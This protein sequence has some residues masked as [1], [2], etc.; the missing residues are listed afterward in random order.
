MM[1]EE[2]YRRAYD[3]IKPSQ[4]LVCEVIR[5]AE[6]A[7]KLQGT[8]RK[9]TVWETGRKRAMWAAGVLMAVLC[10][11]VSVLPVCAAKIPAFYRVIEYL[12]PALADS[13][14]PIEK[15]SSD[16]GI[17]MEVE[18]V[19]IEGNEARIIV[20]VR[21]EEG[22]NLD[23]I[24]GPVD[25]FDSY[26]LSS[27]GS[28]QI[29]GGCSFLNY[30][31]E[32][33]RASF[34]V[35]VLSSGRYQ[36]DK[37]RFRVREILCDGSEE[38]REIDLAALGSQADMRCVSLN[39]MGG[40]VE[41]D[42]L[43]DSLKAISEIEDDLKQQWDVLDLMRVEDCAENDFTVT[44]AAYTD[45]ALRLQICM[46]NVRHADR[47]VQPFLV[48]AAG[49]EQ[50]CAFSVSWYEET[51]GQSYQFYEYYFIGEPEE[52]ENSS[53]YGIFYD[54]GESVEGN[55]EVTFRVR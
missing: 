48:D 28:E 37:F 33:G 4:E 43:P 1:F 5:R 53:V 20:S 17:T 13:L 40:I 9:C 46:G 31:E 10:C 15:S 39:G 22:S 47:H 34:E 45:G 14:I 16:Q 54:S 42:D 8:D 24:H 2:R 26:D 27:F 6:E 35:T 18:A 41:R 52:I 55:W 38:T 23:R 7:K 50:S 29:V 21:D 49:E 51:D 11:M 25:L 3:S 12:S 32:T 30:D 19:N 44:G 36:S